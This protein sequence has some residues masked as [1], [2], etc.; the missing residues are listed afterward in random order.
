MGLNIGLKQILQ[1]AVGGLQYFMTPKQT[2]YPRLPNMGS[3]TGANSAH[4]DRKFGRCPVDLPVYTPKTRDPYN[5]TPLCAIWCHVLTPLLY[6]SMQ[7]PRH[8][9]SSSLFI[10]SRSCLGKWSNWSTRR[11]LGKKNEFNHM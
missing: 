9:A 1:T 2:L 3:Y 5:P 8:L 7:P 6:P 11:F 4:T 10:E